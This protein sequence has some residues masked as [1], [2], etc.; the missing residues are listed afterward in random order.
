MFTKKIFI[1]RII[2]FAVDWCVIFLISAA[3]FFTGPRFEWDY[4]LYPSIKMFSAYGVILGTLSFILLPLLRDILLKGNSLGKRLCRLNICCKQVDK[5]VELWQ[6]VARNVT[7]FVPFLDF[8]A[9][10]L[11]RGKTIGDCISNTV[12]LDKADLC[13]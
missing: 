2:A 12:V 13:N 5:K 1:K 7:F 6:L 3:L 11:L 9:W 4:I 10:F 8:I